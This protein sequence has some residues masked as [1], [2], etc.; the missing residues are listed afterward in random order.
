VLTSHAWEN[1]KNEQS[2]QDPAMAEAMLGERSDVSRVLFVPDYNTAAAVM[3]G[4]YQTQGQI[5]TLVVPKYDAAVD[6][7][8]PA[9]AA[10]LLDQGAL[11]L[12]WAGHRP[13]EQR[14]VLTALG[15]Y[16]LEHVVRA[17][18]RL[19]ERDVP[20]SVVYMLEP[21]RFRAPRSEGERAHAAPVVLRDAL[22]PDSVP[23]RVFVTHTRPEPLLG[24][25]QPLHTGRE[26]TIALGFVG[27]GGTLTVPGM[28]FVNRCTW[29]HILA[30]AA[31]VLE[32]PR[33]DLLTPE[34]TAALDGEASPEGVIV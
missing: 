25:L 4:V 23:Q 31:G 10:R 2:H 24:T 27:Q 28:L 6:L 26:R 29:A 32:L 9:E 3:R 16:Q 21:G 15:A 7:F 19:A 8:T 12:D 13:S 30:A 5:W 20:H 34:E 22:Y 17:S 33:E 14:V 1:A 18:L 11:Q